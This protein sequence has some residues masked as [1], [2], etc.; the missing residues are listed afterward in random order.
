M[1]SLGSRTKK[2]APSRKKACESCATSKVRCG[3]EKP[4]CARCRV[5]ARQCRYSSGEE[6]IGLDHNSVLPGS[7]SISGQSHDQI[8]FSYTGDFSFVRTTQASPPHVAPRNAIP[9]L[10]P[11]DPIENPP[12]SETCLNFDNV[13]LTPMAEAEE[14]RN[15]WMR[16]LLSPMSEQVPKVFHPYTLECVSC[17]LRSYPDQML[18]EN[19]V[20]PIIHPMQLAGRN[21]PP[22]LANCFSLVRLWQ[23][24]AHGSEEMVASILKQE[25]QR[26]IDL[27]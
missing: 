26:L 17:I 16:S 8:D 20:P 1:N 19:G 12:D 4:A 23:K 24:R 18:A 25:I 11:T 5:Q 2:P 10:I 13:H 6:T 15:Y 9:S 22:S 14:I 7:P 21:I 3:L 27:V